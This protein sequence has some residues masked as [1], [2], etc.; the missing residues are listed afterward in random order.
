MAVTRRSLIIAGT[1]SPVAGALVPAADARAA[2]AQAAPAAP[3]SGRRS[4]ELQDGWRFALADPVGAGDSSGDYARAMD[5]E[6]DDSAWRQVAVP[7]DWS[8]ELTPTTEH[9]TSSGT[10]FLPGGLGWYRKTFTLPT[11]FA[12]K[13]IS[14]E[15]DGV[16]MDAHVYCN[17]RLVGRHPYGYTGFAFDLTELLHTD[18]TTPN[19]LAVEVRNRLPSSRWYSGS[20]IHRNARLVVTEPVHVARWGT[21]VTTPGLTETLRAGHALVRVET[22]V[23]NESGAD[24]TVTVV[25]TVLD[26]GGRAVARTDSVVSLGTKSGTGS[27]TGSGTVSDE[28]RVERPRLWSP[29]TPR[30]YTLRTELRV[31]GETTDVH[32]TVFGIRQVTIDAD[33]GMTLNGTYTKLKGVNLHHDLGALGAAVHPDA[34]RRQLD[35][36]KSMGVN[37]VRTS[38]NPPSPELIAACDEMG[39]LMIVEA[40]D[41]WQ[42]GK[43]TY[44]YGRFF[45]EWA[46]A[47]IAE[48]VG[49]ARNSP[50]VI[51]WSIGN[52]VP[53]ST[54]T[55][56]LAMAD[57]LID[58]IR[59]LDTTRPI[60][61]GSDRH[62]SVPAAGSPADLILAKLDGLG[63]NYNTAASTD[64]LHARHPQL[65]L[66]ES[67][68]S[69]LLAACEHFRAG[70]GVL[71]RRRGP[72][73]SGI[74][75][76][77]GVGRA[78]VDAGAG[79]GRGLG[80]RFRQA[81]GHHLRTR[82]GLPAQAGYDEPS[83]GRSRRG[84]AHQPSRCRGTLNRGPGEGGPA[85]GPA[86]EAVDAAEA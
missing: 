17:G 1:A 59:R 6:F 75:R 18:G 49:A 21:Q 19:V 34:V 81:D 71:H 68:S 83:S 10:G 85:V 11:A 36:M 57:R 52:E 66:F 27:G 38:H 73:P 33:D 35:L 48:M 56:G 37:A 46:D 62:R 63:L 32:R 20:G 8:I 58:G 4:V 13:R 55:A 72:Y 26:P 7:H 44:D 65:F 51:M 2:D 28:L 23:V 25:S 79:R 42:R 9:R 43:N 78:P 3:V 39:L 30:L 15:F 31:D 5:P 77:L 12:G 16:H 29:D 69:S 24:R 86:G 45:N 50:A 67:E 76:G 14:A 84:S 70:G 41:C 22:S 54:S 64:A 40:F 82:T 60:V 61:I 47:D 53:D 74:G 80:H